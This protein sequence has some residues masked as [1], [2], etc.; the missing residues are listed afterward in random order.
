MEAL[1]LKIIIIDDE[2][3]AIEELG[4]VIKAVRQNADIT[5]FNNYKDALNAI[6]SDNYDVAFLDIAM[7]G[8]DGL[9]LARKIREINSNTNIIFVTG[10]SEYALDAFSVYASGYLLKPA[11]E[12]DV[13]NALD[14][15][16]VPVTYKKDMLKVQCFGNFEVFYN[17]VP[18]K[19]KRTLTKE[20]FAYLI[21]LKGA[22]AT[23]AELC[24]ILFG[25]K[26]NEKTSKHY[27]RNLISDLKSTLESYN[28]SDVFVYKRNNF[29]I[30]VNKVECDYYKYLEYDA[31][32]I[33]S[34]TGEYMSQYS[35]AEITNGFLINKN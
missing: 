34:Y 35:W 27:F 29:S 32:A 2:R 8:M 13:E 28:C 20:I 15:L 6:K 24:A 23:T 10:Y 33:N 5:S 9:E 21:N 22:S 26:S 18:V 4:D 30:D 25:D 19:F 3:I 16:R 12:K 17:D 14:N 31:S 1:L 7:P 11:K